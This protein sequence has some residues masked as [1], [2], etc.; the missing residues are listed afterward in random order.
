MAGGLPGVGCPADPVGAAGA[1]PSAGPEAAAAPPAL[2]TS[3]L[4]GERPTVAEPIAPDPLA[5]SRSRSGPG[6]LL[7]RGLAAGGAATGT[8]RRRP[9]PD[10]PAAG[11][12]GGGLLASLP[13]GAI[14][15]RARRA[16][17]ARPAG[18]RRSVLPGEDQTGPAPSSAIVVE[19]EPAPDSSGP[20]AIA[21]GPAVAEPATGTPPSRWRRF[22]ARP[23]RSGRNP[24]RGS[25]R[26]QAP[27]ARS[28]ASSPTASVDAP[29]VLPQPTS[30]PR[31][32]LGEPLAS[33]PPT[34][35]SLD[36]TTWSTAQQLR[37]SRALMRNQPLRS[38]RTGPPVEPPLAAAWS[39]P[40]PARR[41]PEPPYGRS[42]LA[43]PVVLPTAVLEPLEP[44]RGGDSLLELA[45]ASPRQA[46]LL[47]RT[48]WSTVD[49]ERRRRRRPPRPRRACEFGPPSGSVTASTSW[50]SPSTGA[51]EG[52]SEP[53]ASRPER[54][55]QIGPSSSPPMQAASKPVP[56]RPLLAHEL[57]HVA[58]RARLGP[59]L[60][61]EATPGA[62]QL[63]VEALSAELALAAGLSSR[64][65]V[66]GGAGPAPRVRRVGDDLRTLPGAGRPPL[67]GGAASGPDVESLA[68][69]ILNRMSTLS[70]PAPIAR[71][72]PGLHAAVVVESR[73][74]A[75]PPPVPVQ[76]ADPL[77][78]PAPAAPGGAG[79]PG[80]SGRARSRIAPA[81]R[82]CTTSAA[83]YIP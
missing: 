30:G 48:R 55:P 7:G 83:G 74:P 28:R 15:L 24:R 77:P 36:I 52:A 81:I 69:S 23:R 82:S 16:A 68:T 21:P 10:C 27:K 14:A 63:E 58:Q 3:G 59:R 33:L 42:P 53:A 66:V 40:P 50:R 13:R 44:A 57:T 41:L 20:S 4:V 17:I 71:N 47:C 60:P 56:A 64:P 43:A 18:R 72:D 11:R 25:P 65:A 62:G 73:P 35:T 39:G 26:R 38:T 70:S 49:P 1:G 22:S 19:P 31:S 46:P 37:A 8:A 29:L 54:S 79:D 61:P 75:P 80:R 76:R 34:A 67:A 78:A 45:P 2:P 32:G 12:A 51:P 5:A 6:H 9:P